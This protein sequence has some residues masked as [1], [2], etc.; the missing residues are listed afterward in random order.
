MWEVTP[1]KEIVWKYEN[2]GSSWRAYGYDIESSALQ[3]L[4]L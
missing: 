2:I 1:E 3:F 4:P